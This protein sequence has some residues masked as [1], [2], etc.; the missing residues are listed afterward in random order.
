MYVHLN[1]FE[2]NKCVLKDIHVRVNLQ[3]SEVYFSILKDF[4]KFVGLG[5]KQISSRFSILSSCL[6]FT[7]D[8]YK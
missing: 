7:A 1:E 4:H 2:E 3:P 6:T 5:F 8:L